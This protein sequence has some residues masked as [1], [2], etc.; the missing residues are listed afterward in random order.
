[1]PTFKDNAMAPAPSVA[2]VAP[3]SQTSA[4]R[5]FIWG[6]STSSYQIEGAANQDGRGPSI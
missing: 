2:P 1:M 6:V 3:S 5:D 4:S